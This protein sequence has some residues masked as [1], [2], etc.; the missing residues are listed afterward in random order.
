MVFSTPVHT[1]STQYTPA[2]SY[3][4]ISSAPRQ[5]TATAIASPTIRRSKSVV[6][7]NMNSPN[8]TP[9]P[10]YNYPA[11]YSLATIESGNQQSLQQEVNNM[12][13]HSSHTTATPIQQSQPQPP[14]T[15]QSAAAP[16]ATPP[17]LH[18]SQSHYQMPQFQT[19]VRRDQ[20]VQQETLQLQSP[21]HFTSPANMRSFAQQMQQHHQQQQHAQQQQAAQQ[22]RRGQ[23]EIQDDMDLVS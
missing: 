13:P 14:A 3:T 18:L 7:H 20:Y 21:A 2:S 23:S 8:V 19:P 4:S 10:S 11:Q 15:Y 22:H 5:Q 16:Y 1:P 17:R 12:R 6:M 9:T